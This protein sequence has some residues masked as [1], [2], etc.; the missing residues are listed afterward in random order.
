[1]AGLAQCRRWAVSCSLPLS[2]D[3][4]YPTPD[5]EQPVGRANQAYVER[6]AS[7]RSGET[8]ERFR[9]YRGFACRGTSRRLVMRARPR[10]TPGNRQPAHKIRGAAWPLSCIVMSFSLPEYLVVRECWPLLKGW[11]FFA[12]QSRERAAL[13]R[14]DSSV[15]AG[16]A[17]GLA[18]ME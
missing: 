7:R 4:A 14:M 8:G 2:C 16:T 17:D 1:M 6:L 9:R 15:C 10:Q 12:C 3:S 18:M 5:S 13:A 11:S